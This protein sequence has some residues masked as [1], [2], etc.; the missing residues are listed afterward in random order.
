[1]GKKG[2]KKMNKEKRI[3]A[4]DAAVKANQYFTEIVGPR[5]NITVEEVELSGSGSCW[6]ITLGYD[7]PP[8]G[9][10]TIYAGR[11][12]K[13]FEVDAYTGEVVS[14]KIREVKER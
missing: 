1:M 6:L 9:R 4:R 3:A 10:I 2:E 7:E 5:T 8:L 12:Y 14:M 13:I 11:A